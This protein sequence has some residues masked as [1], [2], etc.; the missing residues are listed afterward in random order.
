VLLLVG[1]VFLLLVLAMLVVFAVIVSGGF[2][3]VAMMGVILVSASARMDV[4]QV[5]CL[6]S[7]HASKLEFD[8]HPAVGPH[9]GGDAAH[10]GVV[11]G[12]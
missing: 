5:R 7:W 12:L 2:G 4:G 1:T 10:A 11:G 9:E 3:P 8:S 6:W